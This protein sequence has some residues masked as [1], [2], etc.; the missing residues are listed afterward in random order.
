MQPERDVER[1]RLK[2]DALPLV[3]PVC[4]FFFISWEFKSFGYE[5]RR[6]DFR[7]NYNGE[8]PMALY[9]HMCGKCKFCADQE[10]FGLDIHW[11]KRKALEDGLARLFREHGEGI[12][13]SIGAKLLFG[14]LVG[15][16]LQSLGLISE[17]VHDRT[18]SFVQAFW[19]SEPE[20]ASRNGELALNRLKETAGLLQDDPEDYLYTLYM[21]GEISRRLGKTSDSTL[22]FEKLE[23]LRPT[24]QN[25]SNRFLF[26][27]A[28][29]QLSDPR[30][31]MPEE[32]LNPYNK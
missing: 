20:E 31:L 22:Y 14:A 17:T 30:E 29:Q 5:T 21:I 11:E 7:P 9:Y 13:R 27:L 12:G 28:R 15:D 1:D 19:W 6:T 16:L 4:N 24:H 2:A 10:Y 8:N 25:D 18:H 32:S 3:C 23:S 26:E